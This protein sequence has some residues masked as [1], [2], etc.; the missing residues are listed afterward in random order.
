MASGTLRLH[1]LR[2]A[3]GLTGF[4]ALT[5]IAGAQEVLFL[6]IRPQPDR[7]ALGNAGSALAARE[8]VWERSNARARVIIESVCTGCLGPWA[9]PAPKLVTAAAVSE[10]PAPRG[11]ESDP[12][13]EASDPTSEPAIHEKR[14]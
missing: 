1:F 4:L 7:G 5:E 3:L 9:A 2:A 11:V 8:A 13:L 10:I 14:P 12:P 6:H